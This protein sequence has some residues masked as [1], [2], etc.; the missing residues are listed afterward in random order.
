MLTFQ[1]PTFIYMN[2]NQSSLTAASPF[3]GHM[4]S[5][6]DPNG[7]IKGDFKGDFKRDFKR[8][9]KGEPRTL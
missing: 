8:D 1:R 2:E 9:F 4:D 7:G 3:S 6:G 5:C